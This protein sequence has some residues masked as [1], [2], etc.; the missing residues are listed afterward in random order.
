MLSRNFSCELMARW[1]AIVLLLA[2]AGSMA[3]ALPVPEWLSDRVVKEIESRLPDAEVDASGFSLTFESGG[4]KPSLQIDSISIQNHQTRAEVRIQDTMLVVDAVGMVRG[5]IEIKDINIGSIAVTIGVDNQQ[6]DRLDSNLT[7]SFL[8]TLNAAGLAATLDGLG[9]DTAGMAIERFSL[10]IEPGTG[11]PVL[12]ISGALILAFEQEHWR[13]NSRAIVSH[14]NQEIGEITVSLEH[15]QGVGFPEISADVRVDGETLGMLVGSE[16]NRFTTDLEATLHPAWDDEGYLDRIDYTALATGGVVESGKFILEIDTFELNGHYQ[17]D[18]NALH[19]R[20]FMLK[21]KQGRIGGSGVVLLETADNPAAQGIS[22][23]LIINELAIEP[24]IIFEQEFSGFGGSLT[25]AFNRDFRGIEFADLQLDDGITRATLQYVDTVRDEHPPSFSFYIDRLNTGEFLAYWPQEFYANTRKW[26]KGSLIRGTVRHLKGEFSIPFSSSPEGIVTFQM[27]DLD[28]T[29]VRHQLPVI[30]SHGFGELTHE[31]LKLYWDEGWIDVPDK[32]RIDLSGS[33]MHIPRI[34]QPTHPSDINLEFSGGIDAILTL[35]DHEP[36]RFM[37]KVN[38]SPEIATGPAEGTARISLPLKYPVKTESIRV[39]VDGVIRNL[40]AYGLWQGQSISALVAT[41]TANEKQIN[42]QGEAFVDDVLANGSWTLEYDGSVNEL[43]GIIRLDK[44]FLQQMNINLPDGMIT[45][46]AWASFG[47]DLAGKNNPEFRMA[48]SLKEM[49]LSFQALS[50]NKPAGTEVDFQVTG[51]IGQSVAIDRISMSSGNMEFAGTFKLAPEG[52]RI[53][54]IRLDKARIPDVYDGQVEIALDGKSSP[55]RLSLQGTLDLAG[56]DT[57]PTLQ[58]DNDTGR[59]SMQIDRVVV[60]DN[61]ELLNV[62]G[63]LGGLVHSDG[64]FNAE[65]NGKTPVTITIHRREGG[66][67]IRVRSDDAGAVA[68]HSGLARKIAGGEMFLDMNARPDAGEYEGHMLI[69]NAVAYD[70]PTLI[71]LFSTLSL[72]GLVDQMGSG[73]ISFLEIKG[74]F[75][76]DPERIT[77]RDGQAVSTSIGLTAEGSY[78][79]ENK[80]LDVVGSLTPN[81][82]LGLVVNT[83]IPIGRLVGQKEGEGL[84]TIRYELK[85]PASNPTITT[86]AL[87]L[88]SPIGSGQL[89][90]NDS[91]N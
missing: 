49:D 41:V 43:E 54:R 3:G 11:E 71:S 4:R 61:I 62:A 16:G 37:N 91:G 76:I 8:H 23:S 27:E 69:T 84:G 60:S 79:L 26:L 53:S 33:S 18:L 17:P 50:W 83:L 72:T 74:N 55:E 6:V 73:G 30:D 12:G 48:S 19:A 38:I 66:T 35:I 42:V 78:D 64:Q 68:R 75:S 90:A 20:H 52:K 57:F 86:N 7:D 14:D 87:T 32:G 81:T 25:L 9:G 34:N 88:L 67:G 15:R 70:N 46:E 59:L 44:E 89:D 45:G 13:G 56:V 65:L 1:L 29:P 5:R 63:Q 24:G 21:S 77:V 36:F 47:I 22:S 39:S 51:R 82:Y 58:S 85:G 80:T 31:E 2:L 28:F 10:N 40:V